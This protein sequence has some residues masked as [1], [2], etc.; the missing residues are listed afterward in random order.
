M[1]QKHAVVI[2]SGFAG[3][4]AATHL[5]DNN[6]SVTLLEKNESPGG[7]ARKFSSNGFTFDMGPSWYWMPDVFEDYFS[8]F[9]KKPSDYYDLIRLDPSYAVIY[10]Q[11]DVLDIPANLDEFKA[12]L[13]EIEP[14]S[15]VQLDEFLAQAKY[16]YQVGIHD[17]VKKPSRSLLEFTSLSLLKDIM[18]MDVFQSMS[19]HVRKFFKSDKIIRLMEF[20]VLFLG[21][22][23]ENIPAL[24]SLMNYADIALGTWYP[25]G[26]MHEIIAGMV[27]LAEEKGV[28]I[29]YNAEVEEIQIVDGLASGVRMKSGEVVSADVVIAGA[30]YHHVDKHLINP[31]YSNYSEA[32]WDKR[33]MAP[34]SL[35]FYL[36]VDKR[37]N[38]LRHHNLFFDEPLGPHADAIYTNPR[39]PEA[40]LFY[41]CV[42]SITDSTVAP[43]GMENLFLLVPLAPDLEDSEETREKYYHIIM[44]RLERISGQEIRSHVLYKRSYAHS[45]FK[46]DYHAYKGNAYGLANT[47]KQTAILKPSLK[48]KKVNNLF[49]TGQLTVP[50]PGV[51]PSLIS[52]YVV[53][54]EVIRENS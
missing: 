48:N 28:K 45:D 32:Y 17:L 10:G 42:P 22:T 50:G 34:S 43:E 47:L 23:A 19:S 44:D 54:K 53:A 1:N 30:D 29:R 15:A 9:G 49:Y 5:A 37:L 12:K 13:E 26:G 18:R 38:N 20:P 24:Y 51:P 41:A 25:K 46:A 27:A 36:G 6:Y 2:G 31:K 8:H 14:G 39:W 40:P 7:R 21:E 11:D 33:V 4:S 3:L 52:G 16:K 35:L